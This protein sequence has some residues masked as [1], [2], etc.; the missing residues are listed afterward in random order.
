MLELNP[1]DTEYA[2]VSYLT[3]KRKMWLNV[4][5][6]I[7]HGLSKGL[8][9]VYI[10]KIY[11]LYVQQILHLYSFRNVSEFFKTKAKPK[12]SGDLNSQSLGTEQ[13][14]SSGWSSRNLKQNQS[15]FVL[16][17]CF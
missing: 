14:A 12:T 1:S 4:N 17:L 13:A 8:T 6:L 2:A 3:E 11:F 10:L 5:L 15:A 16:A 7:F 9:Y